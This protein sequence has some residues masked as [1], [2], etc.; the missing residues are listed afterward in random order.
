MEMPEGRLWP[1]FSVQASSALTAEFL[2][3]RVLVRALGAIHSG[4]PVSPC[5]DARV[6]HCRSKYARAITIG[7]AGP[8]EAM[9]GPQDAL[10]KRWSVQAPKKVCISQMT[11][12]V[13]G[14]PTLAARA[15]RTVQHRQGSDKP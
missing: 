11:A 14:C 4:P 5:A 3:C 10:T 6:A 9:V 7:G 13:K 1:P 2:A 15:G 12:P 8:S